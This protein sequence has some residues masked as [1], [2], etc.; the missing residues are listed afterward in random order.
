MNYEKLR[1]EKKIGRLR[2]PT[3]PKKD[4][5]TPVDNLPRSQSNRK[6]I[7]IVG[8]Q[9]KRD[10]KWNTEPEDFSKYKV[11][12]LPQGNTHQGYH[13]GNYGHK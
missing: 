7:D 11:T 13:E 8:D 12:K 3:R 4:E 9:Y 6:N 10:G 2:N 5:V 1:Q